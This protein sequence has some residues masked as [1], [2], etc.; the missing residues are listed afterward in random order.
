MWSNQKA[1]AVSALAFYFRSRAYFQTGFPGQLSL[2]WSG[3]H[4][5]MVSVL[6]LDLALMKLNEKV[7]FN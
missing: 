1:H 3:S 4:E 5:Q 6:K 7:W 2:P